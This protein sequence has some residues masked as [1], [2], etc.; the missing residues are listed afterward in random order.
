MR[1]LRP[2]ALPTTLRGECGGARQPEPVG[3]FGGGHAIHPDH[4][5]LYAFGYIFDQRDIII[6]TTYS[7]RLSPHS[8]GRLRRAALSNGKLPSNA[9]PAT[10][11]AGEAPQRWHRR[12]PSPLQ[13]AP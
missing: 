2:P 11:R 8:T 10:P 13:G 5:D 6:L 3:G 9:G 7:P 1:T 12:R 4:A